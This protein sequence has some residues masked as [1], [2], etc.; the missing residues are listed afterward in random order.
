MSDNKYN[1]LES[2][3]SYINKSIKSLTNIVDMQQTHIVLLRKEIEQLKLELKEHKSNAV[4][5]WGHMKC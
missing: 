1:G 4:H 2:F 3:A 5:S